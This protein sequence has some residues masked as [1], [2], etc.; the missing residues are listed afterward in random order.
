MVESFVKYVHAL[1]SN[2]SKSH[3]TELLQD[4]HALTGELW[5][6]ILPHVIWLST[7]A[8]IQ[9]QRHDGGTSSLNDQSIW[10]HVFESMAERIIQKTLHL[11]TRL[12]GTNCDFDLLWP[13]PGETFDLGTMQANAGVSPNIDP[14]AKRRVAFTTFP[15]LEVTA[16][17]MG[18]KKTSVAYKAMVKLYPYSG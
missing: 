1:V 14:M 8:E 17:N 15:G 18:V 4:V 13:S 12:S 3:Q 10:L 9:G 16:T 7:Q 11:R 6:R 5:N 2:D